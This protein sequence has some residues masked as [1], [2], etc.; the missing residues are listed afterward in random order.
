MAV[1]L[2]IFDTETT[3]VHPEKGDD[4]I[5]LASLIQH[6]DDFHV[7]SFV[8]LANPGKPIPVEAS[9]VHGLYDHHIAD[10]PPTREVVRD[11]WDAVL[12]TVQE[13]KAELIVCGHNVQFDLRMI[14]KHVDLPSDL[15]VIDTL[16]LAHRV[17]PLMPS[18]KLTELYKK[19]RTGD[20]DYSENAHDALADVWMC[21]EILISY[22]AELKRSL[23]ELAEDLRKPKILE[24]NPVGG[25]KLAGRRFKEMDKGALRWMR[26]NMTLSPDILASIDDALAS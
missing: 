10:A 13:R 3:G 1:L 9:A 20:V 7:D 24:F 6:E 25:R 16:Q 26:S 18:Y 21:R 14:R 5:Q 22:L 19:R 15:H 8:S 23:K 12:R 2:T 11:W 17:E 4:V